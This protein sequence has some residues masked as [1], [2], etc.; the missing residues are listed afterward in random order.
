MG[1]KHSPALGHGGLAAAAIPGVAGASAR[2]GV[3]GEDDEGGD[4]REA[5]R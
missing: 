2:T 1:G 4:V 5:G 3:R